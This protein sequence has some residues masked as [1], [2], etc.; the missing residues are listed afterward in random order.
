MLVGYSQVY[1]VNQHWAFQISHWSDFKELWLMVRILC[2]E[3]LTLFVVLRF[4]F[5][6]ALLAKVCIVR[7]TF[8]ALKIQVNGILKWRGATR[9]FTFMFWII[10]NDCACLII[11]SVPEYL[12]N[13][14]NYGVLHQLPA[15]SGRI[16]SKQQTLTLSNKWNIFLFR[17]LLGLTRLSQFE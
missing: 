6:L 17:Q 15:T 1:T 3:L 4:T 9:D 2:A 8:N 7:K 16:K 12:I 14:L 13:K 11:L 5:S 10:A